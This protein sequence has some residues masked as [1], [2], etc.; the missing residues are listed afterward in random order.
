MHG[1]HL[2]H[3]TATEFDEEVPVVSVQGRTVWSMHIH[4][5]WEVLSPWQYA[6]MDSERPLLASQHV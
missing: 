5:I 2:S 6:R 1:Q 4:V 3:S